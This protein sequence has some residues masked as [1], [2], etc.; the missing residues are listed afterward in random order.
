[1][2]DTFHIHAGYSRLFWVPGALSGDVSLAWLESAGHELTGSL[3]EP[4][5]VSGFSPTR[6]TRTI[7]DVGTY[8]VG[9]DYTTGQ[10]RL[11]DPAGGDDI[12]ASFPP[13]TRTDGHVVFVWDADGEGAGGAGGRAVWYSVT[14]LGAEEPQIVD[15]A[16]A[17]YL[18]SFTIHGKP[19]RTQD[20]AE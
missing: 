4:I 17:T 9:N 16:P 19:D 10:I 20:L 5:P 13:D 8:H 7:S 11:Y 18:V 6:D 14:T 3:A 15:N 12:W 2:T 1:M